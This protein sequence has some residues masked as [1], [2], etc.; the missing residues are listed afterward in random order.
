M[1]NWQIYIT[2]GILVVIGF[3]VIGLSKQV[4]RF[5]DEFQEFRELMRPEEPKEPSR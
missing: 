2:W 3:A 5:R 1:T 4:E